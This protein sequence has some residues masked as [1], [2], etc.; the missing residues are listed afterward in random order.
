[1][2][3]RSLRSWQA[4]IG[5]DSLTQTFMNYYLVSIVT[6]PGL[7]SQVCFGWYHMHQDQMNLCQTSNTR[8]VR[9]FQRSYGFLWHLPSGKSHQ[10]RWLAELHRSK[11]LSE[12]SCV[13]TGRRWCGWQSRSTWHHESWY[14]TLGNVVIH[15]WCLSMVVLLYVEMP[16]VLLYYGLLSAAQPCFSSAKTMPLGCSSFWAGGMVKVL[17]QNS[18]ENVKKFWQGALTQLP[19][20]KNG[21]HDFLHPALQPGWA[22]WA[23]S[24]HNF[25]SLLQNTWTRVTFL[26]YHD[27]TN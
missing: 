25:C 8:C 15:V 18:C 27:C 3:H 13:E 7:V 1:M 5:M 10:F 9:N 17:W 19:L 12:T 22:S 6:W 21:L 14:S 20:R 26:T 4:R 2:H 11:L 16:L 24:L 23:Q